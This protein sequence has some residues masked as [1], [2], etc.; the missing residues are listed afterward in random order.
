MSASLIDL[1]TLANH[2]LAFV[3]SAKASGFSSP[4]EINRFLFQ[5]YG[6]TVREI[7]PAN[8]PKGAIFLLAPPATPGALARI[9]D[10]KPV[11]LQ[12]QTD[13]ACKFYMVPLDL[14]GGAIL[15]HAP[16]SEEQKLMALGSWTLG[17]AQ[18]LSRQTGRC[19]V[20]A[21]GVSATVFLAGDCYIETPDVVEELPAGLPTSFQSLSWNE[22]EIV[23]EFARHELNDTSP[24]GIWHLTDQLLLRP[25]PEKL[26]SVGLG[27]F[28]RYR[29]AGYRHHD[30]E[31]YVENE[32]R[33]DISLLLYNGFIYIIEVKW[34]G[35]ALSATKQLETEQAIKAALKQNAK[36]WVTEYGNEAFVAGAKQLAQYFSTGKYKWAYLAVFDCTPPAKT[37][38]NESLTV[39][40]AHVAPYSPGDFR[41]LRACVDPRKASKISKA[42]QP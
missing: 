18:M 15:A 35:R 4:G 19:V 30:D 13:V 5:S 2:T 8:R 12:I 29:M 25:K 7:P 37:R 21:N 38:Q 14:S 11:L 10:L 3:A 1:S 9:A 20:W 41:I 31:P 28:L 23:Y 24:A 32:G 39:D 22:G 33:A 16:T 40:P 36:S 34:V 42:K 17:H 27:K 6:K 26:M